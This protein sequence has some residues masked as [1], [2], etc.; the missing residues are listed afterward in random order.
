MLSW[1]IGIAVIAAVILFAFGGFAWLH[2][3]GGEKR[4]IGILDKMAMKGNADPT[5]VTKFK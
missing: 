3:T 5:N 4:M 2:K 1:I